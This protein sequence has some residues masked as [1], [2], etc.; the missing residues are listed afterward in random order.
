VLRRDSLRH[1][2]LVARAS[3]HASAARQ[4]LRAAGRRRL[5]EGDAERARLAAGLDEATA[6]AARLAASAHAL[7]AERGGA[8]GPGPDPGPDATAAAVAQLREELGALRCA[9]GPW[10]AAVR[11]ALLLR[12]R[13]GSNLACNSK[14]SPM[15]S[16]QIHTD[17]LEWFR[18]VILPADFIACRAQATAR[19]LHPASHPFITV[20]A[21]H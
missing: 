16:V 7:E 12:M 13:A 6:N 11:M 18:G 1:A 15:R 9:A 14:L 3:Q 21:G 5:G 17:L 20:P 4:R 2:V 19:E 8:S 10:L